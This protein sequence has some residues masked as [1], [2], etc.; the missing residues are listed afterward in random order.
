MAKSKARTH[1]IRLLST[2]GTG[3]SCSTGISSF[4]ACTG[5][6]HPDPRVHTWVFGQ[7]GCFYTVKRLRASPDKLQ[8][9]KHD[10]ILKRV[11]PDCCLLLRSGPGP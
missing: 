5:P 2:A 9:M 1:I 3:A 8:R 11:R 6:D 7:T 10:W 4:S